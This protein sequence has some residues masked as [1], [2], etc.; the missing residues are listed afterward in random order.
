MNFSSPLKGEI[1]GSFR[2]GSLQSCSKVLFKS[3]VTSFCRMNCTT[4]VYVLFPRK[5]WS[6]SWKKFTIILTKVNSCKDGFQSSARVARVACVNMK[7]GVCLLF[8]LV[9]NTDLCRDGCIIHSLLSINQFLSVLFLFYA[10]V[11]TWIIFNTARGY[12]E[13]LHNNVP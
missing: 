1:N 5:R 7:L 6:W 3:L 12:K 10:C 11:P 8:S 4:L 2:R 13:Y 9:W